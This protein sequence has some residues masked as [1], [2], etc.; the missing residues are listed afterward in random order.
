LCE[1]KSLLSDD[2]MVVSVTESWLDP[3]VT[4]GMIDPTGKY[5]V[6]RND[7]QTRQGEGVLCLISK[8]WPSYTVPIPEKFKTID[9]I[10]VTIL[11]DIGSV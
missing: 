3:S 1:F 11:T 4:N 2:Y 8:N 10:A 7:R 6:H 9:I 5:S